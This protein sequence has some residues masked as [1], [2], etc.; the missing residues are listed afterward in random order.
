MNNLLTA[1]LSRSRT[2]L[3]TLA[4]L[5]IAGAMAYINIPKE[6][7]PDLQLPIIQVSVRLDGVSPEDAER[8]LAR[9]IEEKIKNV[10]FY[11]YGASE[12]HASWENKFDWI[13]MIDVLHDLSDPQSCITEVKRILKN[14]GIA[15]AIDPLLHSDHKQNVGS[16]NA[17]MLYTFGTFVCLPCS[18]STEPAAG[19]GIGWGLDKRL[20]FIQSNGFHTTEGKD[21][22]LL[23]FRKNK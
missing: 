9:P 20:E 14:D 3:S 15:S 11:Q 5:L 4:F 6:A 7:E 17:A 21:K 1:I 18:M 23:H 19:L 16:D 2:V 10:E 8:L 13:I 22:S 12:T